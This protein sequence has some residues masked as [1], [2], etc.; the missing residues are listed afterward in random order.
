MPHNNTND[1]AERPDVLTRPKLEGGRRFK[2]S[3]P[4]QPAGDQPTA[5][6]ELSAGVTAAIM[7]RCCWGRRARARPSPWPR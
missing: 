7:I 5:I 2:L 6:A 4:F 3:T 1:L